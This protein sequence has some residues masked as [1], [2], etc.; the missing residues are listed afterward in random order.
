MANVSLK[1]NFVLNA[2]LTISGIIFPII[3]YPYVARILGPEGTGEVDFATSVI[4]YF[5]LFSQLGV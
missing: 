4:S 1:K 3:S 5:A 2:I